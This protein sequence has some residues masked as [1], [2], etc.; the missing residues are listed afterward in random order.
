MFSV[1]EWV[2]SEFFWDG[3]LIGVFY[4]YFGFDAFDGDVRRVY[5]R[6]GGA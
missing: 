4:C 1:C 5:L 6:Y 3:C 2:M